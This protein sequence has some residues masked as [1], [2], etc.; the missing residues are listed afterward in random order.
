MIG[1]DGQ[2]FFWGYDSTHG[3]QLWTANSTTT[4]LFDV[5]NSS[6][7]AMPSLP[8]EFVT[9]GLLY[10]SANDGTHGVT[11]WRTDG[12]TTGTY[13]LSS[14][15][16]LPDDLTA[17]NGQLYFSASGGLWTS[18]GYVSGTTLVSSISPEMDDMVVM[19]GL[20]YFGA[21]NGKL[22]ESDGT[23]TSAVISTVNDPSDLVVADGELYYVAY[24]SANN[25]QVWTSNGTSAGTF[26]IDQIVPR[27]SESNPQD[28]IAAGNTIY[29]VAYD[30]TY[31]NEL[32]EYT[33]FTN[34]YYTSGDQAIE[35]RSATGQTT[36]QYVWSAAGTNQLVERD[37]DPDD[38]GSLD[39]RIYALTDINGSVTALVNTSGTVVERF[40]YN[41]YGSVT[42]LDASSWEST[43]DAYNWI[44]M[45]QGGRYNAN[46]NLYLFD[47]RDYDPSTG[48]WLEQD[49]AGYVNGANRYQA[50][51]SNPLV[52]SDPSGLSA[53]DYNAVQNEEVALLGKL[54]SGNYYTDQDLAELNSDMELLGIDQANI[55]GLMAAY[56]TPA[57]QAIPQ[58]NTSHLRAWA[59]A[60]AIETIG[61]GP[62]DLPADTAA[63][64]ILAESYL[65]GDA[66]AA[67]TESAEA[68]TNA[69]IQSADRQALNG[70]IKEATNYGNV[71]MSVENANTVL[72]WAEE[73]GIS[74]VRAGSSD[75]S[76]PS[77]W[78]ANP[79]QPHIHIP[80]TGLGGHIPVEPGVA[81]R[82][83]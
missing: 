41:P 52:N 43:I 42:V 39:Q 32:W 57:Q 1:F 19:N 54:L 78:S 47:H 38:S 6:G 83:E 29:F 15:A 50:F 81:P 55:D 24:A 68:T 23:T 71:P 49:P 31:G 44:Y 66:T 60:G 61:F 72:D 58:N 36:A 3:T 21:S 18:N 70:L 27:S 13:M 73:Q 12:T 2:I 28:L 26:R 62:E 46:N 17:Y 45:F 48:T 53:I 7:N 5:I 67:A 35:E 10:F 63:G 74:N 77:N 82:G 80:D 76:V 75:V 9:G 30:G 25:Y 16:S 56:G 11:L 65:A 8:E 40:V 69:A 64:A 4:S 22:Y 51:D 79:S 59:E 37:S 20:L 33:N 14:S 34:L